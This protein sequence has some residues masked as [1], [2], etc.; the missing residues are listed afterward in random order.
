[1][2]TKWKLSDFDDKGRLRIPTPLILLMLFLSRHF[3]LLVMGGVS[4]FVGAGGAAAGMVGLPPAWMLPLNLPPLLLLL[5]ALNRDRF[6]RK[7]WWR[8]VMKG[9]LPA[10][11]LLTAG[12]LTLLLVFRH[13]AVQGLEPPVLLELF[14][15]M[16]CMAFLSLGRKLRHYVRECADEPGRTEKT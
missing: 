9:L 11:M 12:Q 10:L 8:R 14:I 1:M 13:R 16:S 2:Q 5:M 7:A 3:L 6:G 4:R 15:L